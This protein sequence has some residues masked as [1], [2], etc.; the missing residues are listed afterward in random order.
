MRMSELHAM[1]ASLAA[2]NAG[3][4][5][6]F[7]RQCITPTRPADMHRTHPQNTDDRP[8]YVYQSDLGEVMC[9]FEYEPAEPSTNSPVV[10]NLNNA[11]LGNK[12]IVL[13]L[14]DRAIRDIEN[15][16]WVD[17]EE[18]QLEGDY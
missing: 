18:Q 8:E 9:W 16:A 5:S 17:F 14:S 6:Y 11:W 2:F 7:N 13:N 4:S 12:D 1:N 3:I 15:E 10:W